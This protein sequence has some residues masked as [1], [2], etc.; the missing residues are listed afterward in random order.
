MTECF[1]CGREINPITD[2]HFQWIEG[3]AKVRKD[4]GP[5][6]VSWPQR[7]PIFRCGTCQPG[8]IDGQLKML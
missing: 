3:W 4:G 1:V 7:K 8:E 2:A 6:A 5:N